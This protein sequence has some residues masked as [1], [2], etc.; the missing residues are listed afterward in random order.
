MHHGSILT[1]Q[2]LRNELNRFIFGRSRESG[3]GSLFRNRVLTIGRPTGA[4]DG[5]NGDNSS[6][7]SE[8]DGVAHVCCSSPWSAMR[9][10]MSCVQDAIVPE[11]VKTAGGGM[12]R[13]TLQIIGKRRVV[14]DDGLHER[15]CCRRVT[16]PWHQSPVRSPVHTR[17]RGSDGSAPVSDSVLG[18]SQRLGRR[19]ARPRWCR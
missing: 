9:K 7:P 13:L 4:K 18:V 8:T 14:L 2:E 16:Q 17:D 10:C 11:F 3:S 12:R 19:D 6:W 15:C 5:L 1:E